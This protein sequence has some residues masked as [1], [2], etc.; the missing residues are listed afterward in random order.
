MHN[1][2][3]LTKFV[4]SVFYFTM[5]TFNGYFYNIKECPVPDENEYRIGYTAVCMKILIRG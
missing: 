3:F 5:L 2:V 1:D 4:F